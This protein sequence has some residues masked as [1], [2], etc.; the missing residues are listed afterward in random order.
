[1]RIRRSIATLVSDTRRGPSLPIHVC[2]F[3]QPGLIAGHILHGMLPAT[4]ETRAPI[5]RSVLL[6]DDHADTLELMSCMFREE[7]FS[8]REAASV[9][10][11]LELLQDG[12]VPCLVVSDLMMPNASGHDLLAFLRKSPIH[13][14]IPV[15]VVTGRD[16]TEVTESVT[17]VLQKPINFDELLDISRRVISA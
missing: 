2:C 3:E 5:C 12:T 4:V 16:G 13:R 8:T 1:M 7:G 14:D 6:L 11:A 9:D 17:A 15:I 10:E